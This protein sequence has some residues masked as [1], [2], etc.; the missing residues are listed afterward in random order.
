LALL[1]LAGLA[2]SC[3]DPALSRCRSLAGLRS[4]DL[5]LALDACKVASRAE[6]APGV[7]ARRHLEKVEARQRQGE[8][9]RV[10]RENYVPPTVTEIWCNELTDAFRFS[11]M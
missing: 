8:T 7:E 1:V 10:A 11:A 2:T 5:K 4:S 9:E 3:T 6:G